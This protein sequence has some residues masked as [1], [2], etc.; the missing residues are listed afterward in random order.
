MGVV[1]TMDETGKVL[2]DSGAREVTLDLKL[3]KHVDHAYAVTFHK[4]EG[5]TVE[6][7]ILFARLQPSEAKL[8]SVDGTGAPAG[9]LTG[10]S[11]TTP[12]TSLSPAPSTKGACSQF[13]CRADAGGRAR[14]SKDLDAEP[15]CRATG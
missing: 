1:K 3:Y 4:S 8:P 14:R 15:D 11:V 10:G 9:S 2:V 13:H 5:A 12:L 6:H 7:S